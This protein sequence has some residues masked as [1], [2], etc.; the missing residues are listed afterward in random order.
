MRLLM[1]LLLV[2]IGCAPRTGAPAAPPGQPPAAPPRPLAYATPTPPTLTYEFAD[3]SIA[4]IQAGPVGAIRVMSGAKGAA[5]LKF[6]PAGND[7]RV[8]M[9]FTQFSG[10]FSNSAGGTVSASPADI[11]GPAV[12]SVTPRGVVNLRPA[13]PSNASALE[14]GSSSA[15]RSRPLM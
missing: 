4:D 10:S 5:E 6:E 2:T 7:Q 12:L 14:Y 15:S 8:T 1:G 9:T 13:Q 3:T 11:K